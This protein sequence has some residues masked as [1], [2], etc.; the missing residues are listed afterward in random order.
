MYRAGSYQDAPAEKE[1]LE[2]EPDNIDTGGN[3]NIEDSETPVMPQNVPKKTTTKFLTKYE[4]GMFNHLC[5]E[6]TYFIANSR[7][8]C[9]TKPVYLERA[10]YS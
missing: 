8:L 3:A 6:A 2:D 9:L 10:L 4:R 7:M 5:F 1:F